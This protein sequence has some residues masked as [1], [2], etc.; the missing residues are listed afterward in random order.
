MGRLEEV[1][2]VVDVGGSA[3]S[4]PGLVRR[5]KEKA[6]KTRDLQLDFCPTD[7]VS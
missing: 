7:G 4:P 2:L 3:R 1:M 5:R 6:V